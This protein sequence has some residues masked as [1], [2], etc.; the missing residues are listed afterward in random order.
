MT[1]RNILKVQL[2]AVAAFCS[3]SAMGQDLMARQAKMDKQLKAIDSVSMQRSIQK[4]IT[5]TTSNLYTTWTH[6]AVDAYKGARKPLYYKID[7]RDFSMPVPSRNVTSNFGYRPRFRRQH[8][9][10]DVKL[11][12]GDTVYAAFSGKVR[13][14]GTG[15]G[16]GKY[17]VIRHA[18]GLETV[19][20]H[21]SKHLV[22]EDQ[23]VK[24][25]QPIGLG[26]ISGNARG[27]HLHFETRLLGDPIDPALLFDFANQ[28][29]TGDY[30]IYR[31]KNGYDLASITQKEDDQHLATAADLA[32]EELAA[33]EVAPSQ[34][35]SL[36][37]IHKVKRG[38][39]LFS[40]SKKHGM[41][42][43]QLCKLNGLS[44]KSRLRVGQLIKCR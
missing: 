43:D 3:V 31:N 36:S 13:I 23:Y 14:A 20:A 10:I 35:T 22:K 2:L 24:S 16:Y 44:R 25:G 18:N 42:I 6:D 33:A 7:L 17:V 32:E 41:T 38:E 28:D 8:K 19:Y 27:S 40:I 39:T 5:I 1:Y 21:F 26:G 11:Y 9:G 15:S 4:E 29:V 30:Y 34:S 37:A 12:I